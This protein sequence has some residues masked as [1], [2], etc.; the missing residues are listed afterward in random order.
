MKKSDQHHQKIIDSEPACNQKYVRTKITFYE[1]KISINFHN[2]KIPKE[3]SQYTYLSVI[4]T[5]SVY[6]TVYKKYYSQM[7]L[8]ECKYVV[9][10]EKIP[11]YNTV[12]I[13]CSS[14]D[15]DREDSHY[16]DEEDSNEES[17]FE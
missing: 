11:E 3:G 15:S 8:E 4:L 12:D 14:D 17:N 9:K 1:R 16:F 13:E 7:F 2:D 10:E 5:N 6:T